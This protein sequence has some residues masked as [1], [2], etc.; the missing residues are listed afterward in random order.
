[1][2][3]IKYKSKDG[4][5]KSLNALYTVQVPVVKNETGDSTLDT[6]SQKALTE[7]LNQKANVNSPGGGDF[8]RRH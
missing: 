7:L 5:Y 8:Q 1:M 4:S 3:E 6:I 2:T